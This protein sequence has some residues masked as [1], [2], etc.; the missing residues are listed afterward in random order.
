MSPKLLPVALLASALCLTGCPDEDNGEADA[1]GDTGMTQQDT[2]QTED[3]TGGD[4]VEDKPATV[5]SCEGTSIA[6]E[7]E[8]KDNEFVRQTTTIQVGE[9]VKWTVT[10]SVTHTVTSGVEGEPL[11]GELFDSG[12]VTNGDTFCARFDQ[13]GDW[14]YFCKYHV[15]AGMVGT[16]EVEPQ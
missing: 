4:V 16:I 12:D 3:A 10:G 1:G 14:K 11:V 6:N 8:V 9:V 13:R 2:S 5:V 15:A 7:V